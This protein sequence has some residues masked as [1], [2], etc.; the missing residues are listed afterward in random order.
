MQRADVS[1]PADDLQLLRAQILLLRAQQA[2]FG[3]QP[4]RA[5]D[6]CR[7]ALALLPLSWTFGR[8]A[9]MLFLGFS[10]QT[11][12]QAQAAERLLLDE[13]ES[14]GD[15]A[16]TYALL[17][18]ESLCFIYLQTGQL[19]QTRQIAQVLIQGSTRSGIA[20]MRNLGDWYLGLVCYQINELEAAAQ[21]FTQIVENRFTVQVTTYRDAVAGLALIYQIRGESS[22]AWQ[23]VESISQFDLE[24]RG[25]EEIRTRS[26]R[27]RIHLMQGD[28]EK[29]GR[30][31]DTYSTDPPP[32]EPLMWLEEPQVTR[33]R[34]L[35]ARGGDTDLHL[36]M[37]ILGVL[38]EIAN[39]TH[40]IRY[41]IEILALRT[42]ALD[43]KG[44]TGEANAALKQAVDLAR[45]G[46]FIRVFAD[47]RKPMQRI[48][49]RL[50]DQK[51]LVETIHPI[52]AAF[53]EEE[54]NLVRSA[55]FP[56]PGNLSLIEP[57]TSR[58][59]EV[60]TLLR[61]PLSIKE[62]AQKLNI[63]H[64]TAKDHTINLYGKLGVNRRWDAVAR[65]EEL[66][67]LSPR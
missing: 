27:A 44:E 32:D 47:L 64:A 49:L 11:S 35:V 54:K 43:A 28:L 31:V 40:N 66:N 18:L 15:K 56:S 19:E 46:G 17:V 4:M 59:H 58:E 2:Y 29:A 23:M 9:A 62:I 50:V 51:L 42:L 38:E 39:R 33:V 20:F 30:W 55:R 61:G 53:P 16:D 5:I 65:A 67:I 45:V 34:V 6:F 10:M 37:Q 14:Y 13:Y 21:Y 25:S 8:G 12:G 63:S 24:Q 60:L 57:L 26:L 3:N 48:L 7:Q 1:L 41:K 22:E 52:L 36:A